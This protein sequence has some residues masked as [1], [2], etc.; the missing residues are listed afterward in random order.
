MAQAAA[1]ARQAALWQ[2]ASSDAARLTAADAARDKGDIPA[3]SR[4]YVR[5]ARSRPANESTAAAKDRLA[6][7]ADEARR[8]LTDIDAALTREGNAV[9]PGELFGPEGQRNG[10]K[11]AEWEEQV[12]A[13][14]REYEKVEA[15]YH[16]VP[17]AAGP[18]KTH[19]AK[20]RR[21]PE[22]AVVLNEPEAKALLEAAQPWQPL[23]E[24]DMKIMAAALSAARK[25]DLDRFFRS[26]VD[27]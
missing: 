23:P 10:P 20:Q 27:A 25:S 2:R 3:A 18:I 11:V 5:L 1:E 13:A 7:L 21:R 12:A 15:D 8:K 14:F 9:S 22:V 26:H 19:L 16:E 24:A 6:K 17:A 4:V